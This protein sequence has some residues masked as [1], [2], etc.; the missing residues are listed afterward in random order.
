MDLSSRTAIIWDLDG[1]LTD[2]AEGITRSV[3]HALSHY[4]I[5]AEQESL[6]PFIGPPLV[7]SFREFFGFSPEQ[8]HEAVG[9]YREYFRE[10][11]I[12]ENRLYP[13]IPA[14]LGRLCQAGRSNYLASSKPEPFC[15]RILD[16]FALTPFFSFIAGSGLDG[17][18]ATKGEVLSYLL[19]KGNILPGQAVMIGDRRFDAEGAAELAVPCIG[20]LWG[21]GSR[22]E[23]IGAGAAALAET[24]GE[25]AGLLL[26]ET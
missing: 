6:L 8:A 11:G 12:F 20:V 23:L 24:P 4:G 10:K 9:F 13:E 26:L 19:E 1:T 2:P 3:Q 22:E 17:S 18:L 7:G 15:R 5:Q 21:Y 16:H 14:L 25:L